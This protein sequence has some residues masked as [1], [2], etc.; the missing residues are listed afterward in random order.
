MGAMGIGCGTAPP[1]PRPCPW[2]LGRKAAKATCSLYKA[3][4]AEKGVGEA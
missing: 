2:C 1:D 4:L 3:F